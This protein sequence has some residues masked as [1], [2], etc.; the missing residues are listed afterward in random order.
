VSESTAAHRVEPARAAGCLRFR[1]LFETRLIGLGVVFMQWLA[2]EPAE[3]E[4]VGAQLAKHP[5]R[6]TSARPRAGSTSAC[7][8]CCPATAISTGT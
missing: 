4:N 2:V 1:T 6:S 8:A 5:S 3:L 7:T